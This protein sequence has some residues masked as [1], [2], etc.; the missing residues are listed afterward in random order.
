MGQWY[1]VR[2]SV[3]QVASGLG[4]SLQEG[5]QARFVSAGAPRDAAMFNGSDVM[6]R[7]DYYFSPGA[8]AIAL[9]LV[10]KWKGEP[11]EMPAR[12]ELHLLVG[13]D[14]ALDTLFPTAKTD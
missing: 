6:T 10:A 8:A 9:P 3:S 4:I 7:N 1:R 11:C 14:G 2:L 5:F 13:H 12:S